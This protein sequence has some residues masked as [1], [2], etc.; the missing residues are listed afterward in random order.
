MSVQQEN[1]P[2]QSMP[3]QSMRPS[4]SSHN[5]RNSSGYSCHKQWQVSQEVGNKGTHFTVKTK[6]IDEVETKSTADVVHL[7]G[8]EENSIVVSGG[9]VMLY[10]GWTYR[11][12]DLIKSCWKVFC[13]ER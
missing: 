2:P 8:K 9:W 4:P 12:L 13:K 1:Y 6:V 11:V 5:E 3:R 10:T 7:W